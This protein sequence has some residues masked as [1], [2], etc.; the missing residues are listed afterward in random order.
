MFD[1]LLKHQVENERL[2]HLYHEYTHTS[3]M[4]NPF[5]YFPRGAL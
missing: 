1:L 4:K 2:R 3:E 5:E